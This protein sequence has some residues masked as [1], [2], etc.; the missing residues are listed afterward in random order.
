MYSIDTNWDDNSWE[1]TSRN[2]MVKEKGEWT[3]E[4]E[5]GLQQDDCYPMMN[6][7]YPLRHEPSKEAIIEIDEETN[8]CVVE[9]DGE[10]YL[11][12]TGGGMDFTQCIGLAYL[13]AQTHIPLEF[14]VEVCTQHGIT[15]SGDNFIRVMKGCQDTLK[16]K[17]AS[18]QTRLK[19][20]AIIIGE[21]KK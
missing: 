8:C 9:K 15:Q 5:D 21:A 17:V 13:I 1:F 16:W 12:L 19:E 14:A 11:G 6:Y 2:V 7:A 3:D 4:N 20:I 10:F 18:Y